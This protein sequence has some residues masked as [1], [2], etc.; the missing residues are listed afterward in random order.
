MS[1]STNQLW[2]GQ[3]AHESVAASDAMN[4]AHAASS[5]CHVVGVPSTPAA[6]SSVRFMNMIADD[7]F[8]GIEVYDPSSW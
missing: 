7:V 4:V 5:S 2:F 1:C 3:V 8:H 6:S